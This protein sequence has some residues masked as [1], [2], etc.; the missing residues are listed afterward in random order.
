MN[1]HFGRHALRLLPERSDVGIYDF[2][3]EACEVGSD[4]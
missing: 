4:K 3:F 1:R 2:A